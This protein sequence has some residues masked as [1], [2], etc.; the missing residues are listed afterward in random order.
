MT[1]Y[2]F[3]VCVDPLGLADYEDICYLQV[4]IAYRLTLSHG[5]QPDY[6]DISA[7]NAL[8]FPNAL[9]VCEASDDPCLSREVETAQLWPVL[10]A[11][12]ASDTGNFCFSFSA[13]STVHVSE[14]RGRW[15]L[16]RGH[17][18]CAP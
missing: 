1:T 11:V 2:S 18:H 16:P 9:S 17:I 4:F 14:V 7:S 15:G 8:I 3:T 6:T 10:S 5:S 12:D 13:L